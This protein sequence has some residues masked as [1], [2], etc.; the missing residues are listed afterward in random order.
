MMGPFGRLPNAL[1]LV[2]RFIAWIFNV[3]WHLTI[4]NGVCSTMIAN[5]TPS[6]LMDLPAHV[7]RMAQVMVVTTTPV[8]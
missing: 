3:L 6:S 1:P 5:T 7:D 4:S 2:S 8:A